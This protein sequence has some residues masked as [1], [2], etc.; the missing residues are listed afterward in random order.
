MSLSNQTDSSSWINA[1]IRNASSYFQKTALFA[2]FRSRR[3]ELAWICHTRPDVTAV[4]S[5]ASQIT[6]TNF[7]PKQLKVFIVMSSYSTTASN[8]CIRHQPDDS[9]NI[10]STW[11]QREW[12]ATLIA[13]SRTTQTTAPNWDIVCFWPTTQHG[14]DSFIFGATKARLSSVSY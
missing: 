4:A 10:A 14:T 3:H 1:H 7:T 9:C 13:P 12:Y 6:P 11:K 2:E 5:M 8:T